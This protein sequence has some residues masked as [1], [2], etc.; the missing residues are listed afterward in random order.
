MS[1]IIKP[2]E[3]TERSTI[4][5]GSDQPTPAQKEVTDFF[6][7][8]GTLSK[9]GPSDQEVNKMF[10]T[11]TIDFGNSGGG[12]SGDQGAR[13]ATSSPDKSPTLGAGQAAGDTVKST[14]RSTIAAGGD[15]PPAG[16]GGSSEFYANGG[17]LSKAGPSDQE[18]HKMFGTPTIDFGDS[19]GGQPS[20]PGEPVSESATSSPDTNPTS[21]AGKAAGDTAKS[22]ESS[23]AAAGGLGDQATSA[24]VWGGLAAGGLG[25]QTTGDLE[26][27]GV[28]A[29]GAAGYG[30]LKS[31]GQLVQTVWDGAGAGAK[32][33]YN[34]PIGASK[35]AGSA[36]GNAV[37]S[38]YERV[39]A[40]P[41]QAAE[42]AAVG[43]GLALASGGTGPV[44][45]GMAA[46]GG[47]FT[48][49]DVS[50][51]AS[52]VKR[53]WDQISNIF[54]S[55]QKSPTELNQGF[56]ALANAS[57]GAALDLAGM[58]TGFGIS[59]IK[60]L[61]E[62]AAET[63]KASSEALAGDVGAIRASTEPSLQAAEQGVAGAGEASPGVARNGEATQR[64]AEAPEAAEAP[65]PATSDTGAPGE[66]GAEKANDGTIS[67]SLAS[68]AAMFL[69]EVQAA[70]VGNWAKLA[71]NVAEGAQAGYDTS[72]LTSNL[73]NVGGSGGPPTTAN[74]QREK[75]SRFPLDASGGPEI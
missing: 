54:K 46:A 50:N 26:L 33:L 64:V 41:W 21:G 63:G 60:S 59:K 58:G 22:T 65:E 18:V 68:D 6:Q 8:G 4:A 24:A 3:F 55:S 45:M 9:A 10:G 34:D 61:R 7:N 44:A 28:L 27:G 2:S 70:S 43:V 40:N 13:S 37:E 5:A 30:A 53:D 35:T 67:S 16:L 12:Q 47:A 25:D 32:A 14:E 38:T 11:P 31:L 48:G 72:S 71:A 51:A 17:T 36:I 20:Q 66:A 39:K 19:G 29:A 56:H 1:E 57:G 23:A 74:D 75:H 52:A 42:G 69:P 15:Q 49:L 73:A 62:A